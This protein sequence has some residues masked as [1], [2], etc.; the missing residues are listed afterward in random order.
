M[1]NE[2]Y[3]SMYGGMYNIFNGTEVENIAVD[4]INES[5]GQIINS[6]NS[7]DMGEKEQSLKQTRRRSSVSNAASCALFL[8]AGLS[9]LA[10]C[11]AI[12]QRRDDLRELG[13]CPNKQNPF[14]CYLNTA[15]NYLCGSALRN[16]S[17]ILNGTET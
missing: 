11:A 6:A 17:A 4:F 8:V 13:I 9:I 15:C 3:D 14:R 10:E 7:R 12:P 16:A 2:R 5:T 1:Q